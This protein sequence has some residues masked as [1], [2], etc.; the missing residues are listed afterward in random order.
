MENSKFKTGQQ[1]ILVSYKFHKSVPYEGKSRY[2]DEAFVDAGYARIGQTLTIKD[3]AI[4]GAGVSV[5][6]FNEIDNG[7]YEK[8]LGFPSKLHKVM[9][10]S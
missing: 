2:S 8:D 5:Y 10:E 1:V 6:W 7:H 3:I 9:Y 4:N